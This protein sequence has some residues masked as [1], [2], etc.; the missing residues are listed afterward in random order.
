MKFL[1]I[2]L[3]FIPLSVN[4]LL[5]QQ[6]KVV[7]NISTLPGNHA[8][9]IDDEFIGEKFATA[10]L[11]TGNH[12]IRI[13]ERK[14]GW[15]DMVICDTI[16]YNNCDESIDLSYSFKQLLELKTSPQDVYVFHDDTLH[17]HTPML[18][19]TKENMYVLKKTNYSDVIISTEDIINKKIILLDYVGEGKKTNFVDTHWF[20]IL[21]GGAVVLGSSAAYLKIQADQKYDKYLLTKDRKYLDQTDRLDLFSGIAFG[22][23]QVDFGFLIYQFLFVDQN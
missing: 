3:M 13:T 9:F 1:K 19:P 16:S 11:D 10:E 12:I 21:L 15:N 22:L 5:A 18:I 17:G 7:V 23:L 6:C 14:Y 2:Y 20:K 4:I 8:I